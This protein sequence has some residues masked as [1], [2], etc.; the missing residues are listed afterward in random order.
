MA[1][2]DGVDDVSTQNT[3]GSDANQVDDVFADD[4]N[5]D[6]QNT[7]GD[8]VQQDDTTVNDTE[9]LAQW[10]ERGLPREIVTYDDALEYFSSQSPNGGQDKLSML[11]QILIQSGVPGGVDEFIYRRG[12]S[13]QNGNGNSNGNQ[14]GQNGNNQ[15]RVPEKPGSD[16]VAKMITDGVIVDPEAQKSWKAYGKMQDEVVNAALTP[17][18]Q[19]LAM[20]MEEFKGL[21]PTVRNAEHKLLDR[22]IKEGIPKYK[23]DAVINRGDARSYEQA[24]LMLMQTEYRPLLA[25]I[26]GKSNGNQPFKRRPGGYPAPSKQHQNQASPLQRKLQSGELNPNNYRD[27]L[28]KDPAKRIEQ[29]KQIQREVHKV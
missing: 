23:L 10:H 18:L 24:A 17:V 5:G 19:V 25:E 11:N 20:V 27:T 3:N 16:Y 4:A 9:R 13:Q 7:S 21:K 1:N 29:L 14:N 6:D 12:M 28:S 22:R 15:L 2:E 8:D 26:Y